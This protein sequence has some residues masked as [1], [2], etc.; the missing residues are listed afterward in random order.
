MTD[1]VA[2]GR[3]TAC[4]LLGCDFTIFVGLRPDSIDVLALVLTLAA[5]AKLTVLHAEGM[6]ST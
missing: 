6:L 2:L 5:L 4:C 3:E 1:V